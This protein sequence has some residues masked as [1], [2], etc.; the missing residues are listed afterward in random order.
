[1]T[2]LEPKNPEQTDLVTIRDIKPAPD[3]LEQ[4]VSDMVELFN[5]AFGEDQTATPQNIRDRLHAEDTVT[6][7]AYL[8]NKLVGNLGIATHA[9]KWPGSWYLFGMAIDPRLQRQGIGDKLIKEALQRGGEN[10]RFTAT[11]RPD[12]YASVA[13]CV[14]NNQFRVTKFLRDHFGPGE[15]R[16]LMESSPEIRGMELDLDTIRI[17]SGDID[18]LGEKLAGGYIGVGIERAES[19]PRVQKAGQTFLLLKKQRRQDS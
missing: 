5:K 17:A 15:H 19:D 7:G 14:N 11:A 4:T 16:I 6:V 10:Q 9:G 12:N 8:Q 3:E 2:G 1:M 18:A 13:L